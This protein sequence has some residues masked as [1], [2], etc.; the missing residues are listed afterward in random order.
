VRRPPRLPGLLLGLRLRGD[1]RAE[2]TADLQDLFERRLATHNAEYAR[3]R[4]WRDA[5]SFFRHGA[6]GVGGPPA[7]P[8]RPRGALM[9]AWM[10]DMKQVL[11]A[12]RMQPAFFAIASLTLAIGFASHLAAFSVVDRML[13]ASP[14]HVRDAER[15][16]AHRSR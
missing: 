4:Y 11:R 7:S 3:R 15:S 14:A 9:S 1:R 13:L 2:I 16:C 8:E 5:L 12:I 6:A 10:F